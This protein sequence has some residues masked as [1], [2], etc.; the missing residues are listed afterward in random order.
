MPFV[1]TSPAAE[2]SNG[3]LA[4]YK[5]GSDISA[6]RT[7]LAQRQQALDQQKAQDEEL[8]TLRLANLQLARL[9]ESREAS[10][11]DE[12]TA[13][14]ANRDKLAGIGVDEAQT[15]LDARQF[16]LKR[17][18]DNVGMEDRRLNAQVVGAEQSNELSAKLAPL[19][20]KEAEN[21]VA[22]GSYNAARTKTLDARSDADEAT[23]SAAAMR[24]LG[25]RQARLQQIYQ[26]DPEAL[27][28]IQAMTDFY[29]GAIEKNPN[30]A[31]HLQDAHTSLENQ[32]HAKAMDTYIKTQADAVEAWPDELVPPETKQ[33]LIEAL[34]SPDDAIRMSGLDQFE[35]YK[36]KLTEK[37]VNQQTSAHVS[38]FIDESEAALRAEI[39]AKGAGGFPNRQQ[40]NALKE[41]ATARAKLILGGANMPYEKQIELM[42][43]LGKAL[44]QPEGVDPYDKLAVD[45]ATASGTTR[46][47]FEALAKARE[48]FG[49][50]QPAPAEGGAGQGE[51]DPEQAIVDQ[52]VADGRTP[53]E[54]RAALSSGKSL[55]APAQKSAPAAAE[56]STLDAPPAKKPDA[57]PGNP[58]QDLSSADFEAQAPAEQ[59]GPTVKRNA[60]AERS[61]YKT[62]RWDIHAPEGRTSNA[63][64]D[65]Q[66]S[67]ERRAGLREKADQ[68]KISEALGRF[69]GKHGPKISTADRE[70]LVRAAKKPDT[71]EATLEKMRA[72]YGKGGK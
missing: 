60:A 41:I 7:A 37:V 63:L 17:A 4:G 25:D 48:A 62:E 69:L 23:K 68:K 50:K 71:F 9:S 51:D 61:D 15:G 36:T 52:M 66:R 67:D 1:G 21:S 20:V 46:A 57:K 35:Q 14:R 59:D 2:I 55:P 6:Q 31:L 42:D 64:V 16:A 19:T 43:D 49:T 11:F 10:K 33:G 5:V 27:A 28:T 3:L 45:L 18:K 44:K 54:I 34:K 53:E 24:A 56:P 8:H 40:A 29:A 30:A 58:Q 12:W 26:G 70:A 39:Q 65:E 47:K 38:S 32:L 72:K 13:G 22:A